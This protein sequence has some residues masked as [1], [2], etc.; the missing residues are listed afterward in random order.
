VTS[1][2]R[3]DSP[4]ERTRF[5]IH[6]RCFQA[7]KFA[8]AHGGSA[9]V[10]DEVQALARQGIQGRGLETSRMLDA[11]YHRARGG[12]EKELAAYGQ[13]LFDLLAN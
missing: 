10:L 3:L 13:L 5:L 8:V 11:G 6:A 7:F 9:E 12:N 4:A 2:A 1:E